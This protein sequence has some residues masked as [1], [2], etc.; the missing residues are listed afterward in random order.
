MAAARACGARIAL[1][2]VDAASC[3]AA[4]E[5]L[6]ARGGRAEALPA[7]VADRDALLAVAWQL[8]RRAVDAS[9]R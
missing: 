3:Q 7:D 1:V 5:D 9:M 4:V 6:R 2:D 8:L